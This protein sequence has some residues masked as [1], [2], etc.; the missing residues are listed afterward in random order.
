MRIG[1]YLRALLN[2]TLNAGHKVMSAS[3]FDNHSSDFAVTLKQANDRN[4]AAVSSAVNFPSA[5]VHVS[6]SAADKSLINF[7]VASQLAK[8]SGLHSFAKSMIHKPSSLLSDTQS[9]AEFVRANAVLH[10]DDHPK[11]RKPLVQTYR[12]IL[13][14]GSNFG[15]KLF[16]AFS[17]LPDATGGY[18]HRIAS[19]AVRASDSFGPTNL[20]HE[21]KGI[22]SVGEVFN[23]FQQG[24]WEVVLVHHERIMA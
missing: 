23:R 4:L 11:G 22:I 19:F 21:S 1:E 12:R 16:A 13:E 18:E 6:R 9:L 2:M 15:A 17:A 20:N 8:G 5:F 7:H 24:L 14:Y 10:I 3:A